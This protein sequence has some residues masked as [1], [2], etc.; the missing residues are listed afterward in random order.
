MR[1]ALRANLTDPAVR[2]MWALIIIAL[3]QYEDWFLNMVEL[4]AVITFARA[5]RFHGRT[6]VKIPL[7]PHFSACTFK[8]I[9]AV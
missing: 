8:T 5:A 3:C 4:K 7:L 1:S 2:T 9:A 6:H